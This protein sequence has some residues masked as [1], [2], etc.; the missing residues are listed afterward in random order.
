MTIVANIWQLKKIVS[1]FKKG[2]MD[3]LFTK[4]LISTPPTPWC[5]AQQIRDAC[6]QPTVQL[7][8]I[9][10]LIHFINRSERVFSFS[11]EAMIIFEQYFDK[12]SK[13]IEK[14][15]TKLTASNL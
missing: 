5:L 12:I 15:I 7:H 13:C 11:P 4:M 8:A 9:F 1:E 3:I 10:F 6:N 2:N 14:L